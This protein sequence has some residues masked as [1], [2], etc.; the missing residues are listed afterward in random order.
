MEIVKLGQQVNAL[1]QVLLLLIHSL[2]DVD[3]TVGED[4]VADLDPLQSVQE[5]AGKELL[6]D[7][8][9]GL[10]ELGHDVPT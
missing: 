10:A 4:I 3:E 1:A 7:F 6:Q 8:M 9:Q 5:E 2:A